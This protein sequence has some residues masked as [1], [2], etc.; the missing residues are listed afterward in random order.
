M[1]DTQ[2]YH[3]LDWERIAHLFTQNKIS[4]TTS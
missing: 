3:E 4:F 2:A 1:N